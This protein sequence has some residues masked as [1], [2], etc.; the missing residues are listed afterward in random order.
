MAVTMMPIYSFPKRLL[1]YA[2]GL[3]ELSG[4]RHSISPH[5][6]HRIAAQADADDSTPSSRHWMAAEQMEIMPHINRLVEDRL[7]MEWAGHSLNHHKNIKSSFCGERVF[8][9]MDQM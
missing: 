4:A 1:D 5:A 9:D 2:L 7:Y 8:H 3:V 6:F